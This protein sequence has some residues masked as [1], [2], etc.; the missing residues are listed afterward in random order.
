LKKTGEELTSG[1]L[2]KME[3]TRSEQG[4][5]LP[6]IAFVLLSEDEIKKRN[7]PYAKIECA[8]FKGKLPEIL[9]IRKL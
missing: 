7:F 1:V 9:L 4:K 2:K 5:S 8:R 6:T 3:L